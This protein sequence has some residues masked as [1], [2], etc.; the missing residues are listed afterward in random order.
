MKVTTSRLIEALD[1]HKDTLAAKSDAV[2]FLVAKFGIKRR[3][4]ANVVTE[5]WGPAHQTPAPTP[6]PTPTPEPTPT[7]TPTPSQPSFLSGLS[8]QWSDDCS[9]ADPV[10]AGRWCMA[11]MQRQDGNQV[12]TEGGM[13]AIASGRFAQHG[14]GGPQNKPYYSFHSPQG[15]NI[16]SQGTVGRSEL[17][18]V[19]GRNVP[20]GQTYRGPASGAFFFYEGRRHVILVSLRLPSGWDVNRTGWRVLNQWKQNEWGPPGGSPPL[21]LEQK[22]GQ[23]VLCN[24]GGGGVLDIAPAKVGQWTNFA[25]DVSF[26]ADPAKGKVTVYVDANDDGAYELDRSWSGKN[27]FASG[28]Q[29]VE[30]TWIK[31]CYEETGGDTVEQ[32]NHQIWG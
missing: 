20:A 26:S 27:M 23:W 9:Q 18:Y 12:S 10:A 30:S 3:R 4:A 1:N 14:S 24:F 17:A 5:W 8:K 31:G 29:T 11:T 32:A 7:P 6:T 25:F 22:R 19:R 2:D 16:W 28:G 15:D 21:A 13:S